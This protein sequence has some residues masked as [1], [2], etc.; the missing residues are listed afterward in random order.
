MKLGP[1]GA[2]ASLDGEIYEAE[3][4]KVESGDRLGAGDAFAA[5]L[6]VSLVRGASLAEAL[7]AGCELGARSIHREPAP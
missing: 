3:P 1:R 5:G 7:A 2:V 6:L 4:A